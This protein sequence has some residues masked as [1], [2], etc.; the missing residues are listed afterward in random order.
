LEEREQTY[1]EEQKLNKDLENLRNPTF[2]SS[3]LKLVSLD[4]WEFLHKKK[5]PID[6]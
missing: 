4:R 2:L 5:N 6:K 3:I 1:S